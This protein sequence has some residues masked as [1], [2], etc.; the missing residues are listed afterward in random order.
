MREWDDVFVFCMCSFALGYLVAAI[1]A[2]PV[3]AGK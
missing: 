2:A 3:W 1:C